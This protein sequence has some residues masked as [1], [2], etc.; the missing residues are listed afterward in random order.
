VVLITPRVIANEK[1]T[2]AISQEYKEKMIGL[3]PIPLNQL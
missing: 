1:D 2:D 3:R